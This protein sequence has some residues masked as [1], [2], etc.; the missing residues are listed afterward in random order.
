MRFKQY[1]IEK[2]MIPGGKADKETIETIAKKH[3]VSVDDIQK[4]VNIGINIEMEHVNDKAK[5]REISLDHLD[6]IPDYY[7]RLKKM[8]KDAGIKEEETHECPAGQRW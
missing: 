4:Q 2:D 5:A 6:E 1:L 8:E 7:T 3:G